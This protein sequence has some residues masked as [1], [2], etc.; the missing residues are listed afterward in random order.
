MQ[1]FSQFILDET[2]N[3]VN[4]ETY[5]KASPA[6]REELSAFHKKLSAEHNEMKQKHDSIAELTKDANVKFAHKIASSTHLDARTAHDQLSNMLIAK[7]KDGSFSHNNGFLDDTK[8]QANKLSKAANARS[9]M[10]K[11]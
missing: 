8:S 3:H 9:D 5:A 10:T 7:N 4:W 1:T 6:R 11:K 2:T